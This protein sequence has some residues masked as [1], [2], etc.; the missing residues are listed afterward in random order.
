MIEQGY[1]IAIVGSPSSGKTSTAEALKVKL[2]LA[3]YNA[4]IAHEYPRTYIQR[5]G[6]ADHPL[7]QFLILER[8]A[9]VEATIQAHHDITICDSSTFL[10]YIYGSRLVNDSYGKISDVKLAH[11]KNVLYKSAMNHLGTYDFI[12]YV[13]CLGTMEDDGIRVQTTQDAIEIDEQIVGFLKMEQV[14]FFTVSGLPQERADR[15]MSILREFG[16]I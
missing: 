14:P 9:Q 5:Y 10:C 11:F 1:K 3:G 4:E 16:V 6:V 13:P 15:I 12:F 7:E 2:K 8:Q